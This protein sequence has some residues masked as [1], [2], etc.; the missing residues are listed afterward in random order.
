M[1][2]MPR[3]SASRCRP[4]RLLLALLALALAPACAADRDHASGESGP[5]RYEART[6]VPLLMDLPLLGFLFGRRTVV[7]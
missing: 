6:G 5:P 2:A 4:R 1:T 3:R 7:R